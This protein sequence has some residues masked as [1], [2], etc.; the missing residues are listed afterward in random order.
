MTSNSSP[1]GPD[2]FGLQNNALFDLKWAQWCVFALFLIKT[3]LLYGAQSP[4][5][6]Q[7]LTKVLNQYQ[8]LK[9]L[10][11]HFKQTKHFANM[12]LNLKA[13]GELHVKAD[14]PSQRQIQ[15][16]LLEPSYLKLE[17]T[18]KKLQ[19]YESPHSAPRPLPLDQGTSARIITSLFG[20]LTMN[21]EWL[22]KNF[23]VYQ[24]SDH[25]YVF[26]PKKHSSNLFKQMQLQLNK[27][28][29][30]SRLILNEASG[31]QLEIQFHQQIWEKRP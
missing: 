20:W 10:H 27:K 22:N 9:S 15:W 3:P 31:D 21:A 30:L 6:S 17:I 16:I 26:Q 12:D 14:P 28:G 25:R 13:K 2:V 7:E 18:K 19:I 23:D 29:Q 11:A 8:N 4:L 24:K 1:R 5:N